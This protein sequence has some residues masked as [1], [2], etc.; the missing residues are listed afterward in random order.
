MGDI[1]ASVASGL[2]EPLSDAIKIKLQRS[3]LKNFQT[4]D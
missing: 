2:A 1:M 3:R 4:I